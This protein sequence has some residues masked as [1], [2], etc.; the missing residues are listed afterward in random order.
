MD[1]KAYVRGVVESAR[2]ASASVARATTLQKDAVLEAM[3]RN[4]LESAEELK[5]QNARDL[6]AGTEAGLSA[7]ML[8]RLELNDKRIGQMAAGIR[9]VALLKDPVGSIIAGWTAPN[10]LRLRKVRVPIGV[11]AVIYES[12]PNVT[13][14]A[15]CL[16]L[17]SGNALILRGGKEAL[18]SNIAIQR[19][20]ARALERSSI[21]PKAV[22]L[23][24]TPDRAAVTE[25]LTAEGYVDLA[26]PRGG[27]GLIRTVVE[28]ATVPVIKHY[29]GVC[30]VFVDAG[31]DLE[32]AV[33]ICE[34]A[35]CQ[36]P[37]ICNAMECMLVHE[38]VAEEFLRRIG[39]VFRERGVE[40]RGCDRARRILPEARAA[41]EQDWRTEYLDLIL[42]VRVVKDIHE[43][44]DHINTYGSH[45]TDAIVTESQR[46]AELFCDR[47][48]SAAVC[49]NA[50]TR[51]T[52]GGEFGLGAEVGISTDKLHARGPMGLEELTI[53][54]WVV[55]GDGQLRS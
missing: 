1:V 47:V 31:C 3:A 44:I 37:A 9:A 48:D 55:V 12:R 32:M 16:C 8:D 53:Y 26:V 21:D 19:Q 24:E 11:I 17:K 2:K 51:M 18:H 50:S 6:G 45:H 23:I 29:E 7:A 41:A 33:R 4:L 10:G 36:G 30:H 22:Q 5:R 34:N 52:D 49:V 43:A 28:T 13:A 35:K 25:L 14:D 46:N 42:S 38:A 40:L 27:K 15:A 54:K 20:I 39:P